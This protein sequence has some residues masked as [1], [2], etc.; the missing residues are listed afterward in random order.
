MADVSHSAALLDVD[1]D[2]HYPSSGATV[3]DVRFQVGQ[4][5]I[6]GLA[7]ESGS[8]KSTV[9]LSIMGLVGRRGG[10]ARGQVLF[11][12]RNLLACSP[13]EMRR[14]RG[15]DLSLLLQNPASALNP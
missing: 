15:R 10:V 2:V 13:A 8:G 14:I 7:G 1:L 4:G 9:A 6:V 5:E 3:R 12:D 11:D